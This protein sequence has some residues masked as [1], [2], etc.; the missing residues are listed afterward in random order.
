M[1]PPTL[2]KG[3]EITL[4]SHVLDLTLGPDE[5]LYAACLDGGIYEVSTGLNLLGDAYQEI[6]RHDN[7]ASGLNWSASQNTLV[8]A[9]YD[10]DLKWIDPKSESEKKETRSLKA[11]NFW[12]WQSRLSPDGTLVATTTGQYLCGGY[13]YEPAPETEPSVKVFDVATGELRHAFPHTPPVQSVAFSNN[14]KLLAAGN[15]MGEVILWD[16]SQGGQ[17]IARLKTPDFTGWGII[18]G[19]YYTGGV[20]A[21][22]FAPDDQSLYLA[23]MGSTTDPAAGNGKQL[24]QKFTWHDGPKKESAATASE[25][26]EGLM[27]T[28]AFHPSG[29]FFLM[30]GRIFKG[31]WNAALFDHQSGSRLHHEN[32][33]FRISASTFTPD[34][35]TL[36]LAGG[37]NQDNPAQEKKWGR[38]VIYEVT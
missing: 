38:I 33:G 12:S 20:F 15:L 17:E 3:K 35:K 30:A 10:G 22:L 9:S 26:G 4:P 16:L 13:K 29:K 36:Y 18:K 32:V 21:L 34:G 25:I 27:E 6:A 37:A 24:W 28:L 11:H 31:D 5:K 14:G 1:N 8:S 2:K 23:G 19:H 7:Y